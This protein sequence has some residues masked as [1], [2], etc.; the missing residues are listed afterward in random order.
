MKTVRSQR[1]VGA[2]TGQLIGHGVVPSYE[3]TQEVMASREEMK[4]PQRHNKQNVKCQRA[5]DLF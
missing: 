5:F 1:E 4:Y 3:S 2:E